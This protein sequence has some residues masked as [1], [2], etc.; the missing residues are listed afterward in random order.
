[1][2]SLLLAWTSYGT[3]DRFTGDLGG[4]TSKSHYLNGKTSSSHQWFSPHNSMS[5]TKSVSYHDNENIC[6]V[7]IVH[8]KPIRYLSTWHITMDN[9]D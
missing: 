7:K 3:N 8:N 6:S 4:K 1:M 9:I 2:I 5:N